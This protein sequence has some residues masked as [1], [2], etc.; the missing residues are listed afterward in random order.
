MKHDVQFSV[1]F[2][3]L[4]KADIVFEITADGEKFGEL[5]VSKGSLVW[6]PRDKSYG[7][8]MTWKQLEDRMMDMPKVEK[9]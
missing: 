3:E 8:K 7:R 6:F 5:R 1:P 9:R 4:G 2:R